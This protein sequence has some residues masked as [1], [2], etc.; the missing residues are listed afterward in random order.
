M[1]VWIV[2]DEVA[3]FNKPKS[4]YSFLGWPNSFVHLSLSEYQE[5]ETEENRNKDL[6]VISNSKKY[7]APV[8][9][10]SKKTRIP[11]HKVFPGQNIEDDDYDKPTFKTEKHKPNTETKEK[12]LLKGENTLEFD[13]S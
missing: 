10:E 12:I 7:A 8:T 9:M 13:I 2:P 6:S 11:T 4:D 1:S 3:E 5:Q